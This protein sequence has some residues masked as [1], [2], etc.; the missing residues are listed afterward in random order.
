MDPK[1]LAY[2]IWDSV[3]PYFLPGSVNSISPPRGLHSPNETWHAKEW[4]DAAETD[5]RHGWVCDKL[6]WMD[7]M[8]D[9]P[10]LFVASRAKC[11]DLL[12][13]IYK[14]ISGRW[15]S[16][17]AENPRQEL[18]ENELTWGRRQHG[19]SMYR[20][21]CEGKK[22]REWRDIHGTHAKQPKR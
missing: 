16:E 15:V 10:E 5:Y 20:D 9:P 14:K 6:N 11:L 13:I 1:S 22:L 8:L 21:C 2:L 3:C 18:K 17:K 7:M 12:V 4:K 19:L